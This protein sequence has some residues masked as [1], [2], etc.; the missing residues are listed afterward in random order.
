MSRRARILGRRSPKAETSNVLPF[1]RVWGDDLEVLVPPETVPVFVFD[2]RIGKAHVPVVVRQAVLARPPRD[3]LR[4][5]IRPA[6]AV[7]PNAIVFV[8]ESLIVDDK[9]RGV[10]LPGR[11]ADLRPQLLPGGLL[12]RRPDAEGQRPV[13]QRPLRSGRSTQTPP[14]ERHD[15]HTAQC[16]RRRFR[17]DLNLERID[18]RQ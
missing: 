14:D 17:Y 2:A 11:V 13:D 5:A 4:F 9:N 15:T 7:F 8:E 10:R 12:L 16:P 3:V 6:V 18:R 1:G